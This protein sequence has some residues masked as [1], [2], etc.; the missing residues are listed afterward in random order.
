MATPFSRTMRSL[1]ADTFYISVLTLIIAVIVIIAWGIWFFTAKVT[2][3]AHSQNVR[4]TNE[5]SIVTEFPAANAR[6]AVQRA[7][8][9]RRRIVMADFP[10]E[11]GEKI[12]PQQP[13]YL[14]IDTVEGKQAGA[15]PAVV[16]DVIEDQKK[17]HTQVTLYAEFDADAPNPFETEARGDV[18]IEIRHE[19]PA[20]LVVQA[21]GLFTD[22][23]R[24]SFSPQGE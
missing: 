9:T 4:V 10:L 11:T 19:T 15:I 13:A 6:D 20:K 5:E 14:H 3:Y 18:M 2:F 23:P 1:H 17:Q 24:T 22:S 12:H 8:A 16:V 7:T 21:S